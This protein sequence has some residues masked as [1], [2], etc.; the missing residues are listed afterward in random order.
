[1]GD[2]LCKLNAEYITVQQLL[3]AHAMRR[4]EDNQQKVSR[5]RGKNQPSEDATLQPAPT[6]A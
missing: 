1:M 4:G 3:W 2:S 5:K 6:A